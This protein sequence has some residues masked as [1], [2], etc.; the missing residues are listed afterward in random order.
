[1]EDI[2]NNTPAIIGGR[3][4]EFVSL[5]EMLPGEIKDRIIYEMIQEIKG[6][7]SKQ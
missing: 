2:I 1:V 3:K 4:E 5:F 6:L 7:L